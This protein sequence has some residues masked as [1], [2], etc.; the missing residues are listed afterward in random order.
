MTTLSMSRHRQW[1]QDLTLAA[2]T[3]FCIMGVNS[4]TGVM[5]VEIPT[6]VKRVGSRGQ[7]MVWGNKVTEEIYVVGWS[8]SIRGLMPP[9]SNNGR[10]GNCPRRARALLPEKRASVYGKWSQMKKYT[11]EHPP[12]K[13]KAP[14]L[15][16]KE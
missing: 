4:M 7:G 3:E 10:K 16:A 5:F 6:V 14:S 11:Y 9:S 15:R 2:T 1:S 13:D 8:V 12:G